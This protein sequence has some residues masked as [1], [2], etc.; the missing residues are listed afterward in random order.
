MQT[1]IKVKCSYRPGHVGTLLAADDPKAWYGTLA[2]GYPRPS[3]R[4]VTLHVAKCRSQGLLCKTLP[5]EWPWGVMW[6]RELSPA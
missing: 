2:F 3:R 1:G 6:D 5:V 4:L